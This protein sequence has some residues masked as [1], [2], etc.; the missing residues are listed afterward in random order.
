MVLGGSDLLAE[1]INGFD[2]VNDILLG[3]SPPLDEVPVLLHDPL[4]LVFM[5]V[6]LLAHVLESFLQ[7]LEGLFLS[8]LYVFQ[9]LHLQDCDFPTQL[10][11]AFS[12]FLFFVSLVLDLFIGETHFSLER[13]YALNFIRGHANGGT[14]IGCFLEYLIVCLFA[15]LDVDQL[16]FISGLKCVV[17]VLILLT[18]CQ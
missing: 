14:D 12:L 16:L 6:S 17:D 10:L 13:T 3:D 5:L 1:L 4:Q 18:E 15:L 8:Q 9:T 2:V 7:T 11:D